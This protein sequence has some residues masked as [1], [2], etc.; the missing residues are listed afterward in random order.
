MGVCIR[1]LKNISFAIIFFVFRD[2]FQKVS[3]MWLIMYTA[4]HHTFTFNNEILSN[5]SIIG[6]WKPKKIIGKWLNNVPIKTNPLKL[7]IQRV[8]NDWENVK[9]KKAEPKCVSRM[10]QTW[11]TSS[12][13]NTC[14]S[15]ESFLK[16]R[17]FLEFTF[18]GL[19]LLILTVKHLWQKITNP[20]LV[21]I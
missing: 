14:R 17:I 5:L 10:T 7:Y 21:K 3:E 16:L 20:Y 11:D 12:S 4:I 19:W 8:F 1:Y 9:W 15:Y 13:L 6:R 18:S 2:I